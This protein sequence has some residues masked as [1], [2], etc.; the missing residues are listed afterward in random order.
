M[1]KA[2]GSPVRGVKLFNQL[3]ADLYHRQKNHL[4]D[5]RSRFYFKKFF[6]T[7][8]ARDKYLALVITVDQPHQVA[9]HDT[10]L[11]SEP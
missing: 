1:T 10:M 7:V 3:P 8:P 2:P 4:G 5:T 11:V 6:G 9:Q